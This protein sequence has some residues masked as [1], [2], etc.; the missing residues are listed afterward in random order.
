MDI[1]LTLQ[2]ISR[3]HEIGNIV[4]I[5]NI[6]DYLGKIIDKILR[7]QPFYYSPEV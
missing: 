5:K 1:F 6:A 7:F 3:Y 4:H 2:A